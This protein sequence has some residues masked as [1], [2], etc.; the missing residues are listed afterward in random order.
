VNDARWAVWLTV[1]ALWPRAFAC[2]NQACLILKPRRVALVQHR[3][4]G[5]LSGVFTQAD[6]I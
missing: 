4:D 1:S 3:G 5:A 2:A 6:E